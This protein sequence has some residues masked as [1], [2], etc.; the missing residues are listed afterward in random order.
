MFVPR[1][2]LVAV[3]VSAL[4]GSALGKPHAEGDNGKRLRYFG[5]GTDR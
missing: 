2:L 1:H 5:A 3:A 4:I